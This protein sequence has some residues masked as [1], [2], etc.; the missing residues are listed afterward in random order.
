MSASDMVNWVHDFSNEMKA[1]TGR[2]PAIYSTTDWWRT[3]TGNSAAFNEDPLHIASYAN[4]VGALPASWLFYSIWQYSSTGPFDGDSDV[5]N[6]TESS[7]SSF[8]ANA[9]TTSAPAAP[10]SSAI[11]NKA[12]SLNGGLGAATSGEVYGLKDGG[13]FQCFQLGCIIWSPTTGARISMGAIRNLW[14]ATG[15][16]NGGLGY[17]TSDEIPDGRGGVYQTYQHGAIIYAPGYGTFISLGAIRSS[18]LATGGVNGRLGYPMSNEYAAGNGVTAQNFQGG[19]I[20]WVA[21]RGI[22]IIYK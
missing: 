20:T 10:S 17:P 19:R 6:G 7:L 18:W 21:T 13:G 8:A 12:A 15:Y 4:V 16:E 2:V 22:T 9:P 5:W 1:R 11:A 3:C 14:A